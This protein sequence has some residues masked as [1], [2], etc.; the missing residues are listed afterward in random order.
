MPLAP[1]QR[2]AAR[3]LQ[4]WSQVQ[5]AK[6]SKAAAK[7]LADFERGSCLPYGHTLADIQDGSNPLA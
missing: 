6:V 5:F 2:R 4:D 1:A 7:T 3:A